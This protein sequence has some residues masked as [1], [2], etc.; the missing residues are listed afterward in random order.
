METI[1]LK[2]TYYGEKATYAGDYGVVACE[3]GLAA[4]AAENLVG[5]QVGVVDEAHGSLLRDSFFFGG[6]RGLWPGSLVRVTRL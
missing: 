5:V 3:V 6:A 2:C 4:F 1:G